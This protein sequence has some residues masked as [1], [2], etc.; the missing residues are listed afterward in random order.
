MYKLDAAAF[1]KAMASIVGM[2]VIIDRADAKETSEKLSQENK[3]AALQILS[4]LKE[5]CEVLG[6]GVT[7]IEV[8][9]TLALVEADDITLE[10]LGHAYEII[11][12]RIRD[13]ISASEVW[14]VDREKARYLGTTVELFGQEATTRFATE[15]MVDAGRCLAFGCGTAAVFH[16]MRVMEVGLKALSS[17]LG[18]PY[19]PSWD[20][21]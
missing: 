17:E 7:L 14:A 11:F 3:K 12:G 19:A 5:A 20:P 16:L 18:I 21:T 4:D 6:A 13:E 9:R 15:D 1:A 2:G 10:G 8:E